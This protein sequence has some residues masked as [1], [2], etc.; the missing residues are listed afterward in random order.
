MW[1]ASLNQWALQCDKADKIKSTWNESE[2]RNF[3]GGGWTQGAVL[4]QEETGAYG[5]LEGSSLSSLDCQG[6]NSPELCYSRWDQCFV[7]TRILLSTGKTRYFCWKKNDR[8]WV[9]QEYVLVDKL[10]CI[11]LLAFL[12]LPASTLVVVQSMLLDEMIRS[13]W[14]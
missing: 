1:N 14:V 4:N 3:W 8:K 7:K 5:E 13:S 11:C 9:G 10:F 6:C 12:K 2:V